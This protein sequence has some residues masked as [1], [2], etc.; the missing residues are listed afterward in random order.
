MHDA[1]MLAESGF[2]CDSNLHAFSPTGVKI[3]G[4]RVGGVPVDAVV[5]TEALDVVYLLPLLS[6]A[7]LEILSDDGS[8]TA[9]ASAPIP[10]PEMDMRGKISYLSLTCGTGL[11]DEPD[12]RVI[13]FNPV[14][15]TVLF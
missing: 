6:T 12:D 7:T 11:N 2:L 3:T 10:F 14:A 4:V 15:K 8:M 5:S 13:L 1:A 9:Y